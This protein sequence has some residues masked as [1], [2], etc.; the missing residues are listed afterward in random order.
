MHIS[1]RAKQHPF[2]NKLLRPAKSKCMTAE[3]N[4]LQYAKES[5][6]IVEMLIQETEIEFRSVRVS[7]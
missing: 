7:A 1:L 2:K 4:S 6:L 5:N 3:S